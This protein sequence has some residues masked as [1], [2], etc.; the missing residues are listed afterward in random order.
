MVSGLGLHIPQVIKLGT[1]VLDLLVML[2]SCDAHKV[3]VVA[4]Y[5]HGPGG[6]VMGLWSR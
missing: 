5:L 3:L 2:N 1:Q 6:R 4:I